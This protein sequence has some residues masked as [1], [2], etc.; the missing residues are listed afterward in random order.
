LAAI[1]NFLEE[2]FA[3]S[4]T[5]KVNLLKKDNGQFIGVIMQENGF[6]V[7]AACGELK[8]RSAIGKMLRMAQV[9]PFLF[10]IIVEPEI[11]SAGDSVF[12]MSLE[13]L[14]AFIKDYNSQQDE[15]SKLKPPP[16]MKILI[17]GEFIVEGAQ[18]TADEF[19]T[20]LVAVDYAKVAEIY[21]NCPLPEPYITKALI[22][23]RKKGAIKVIS[24]D[25]LGG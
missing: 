20:M 24:V 22:D 1:L 14:Y 9:Q 4:F 10:K 11:I 17:R 2:N 8:G 6:I 23:L 13:D 7:N 5:G 21:N 3:F 15:M 25:N 16:N 12:K 19:E 18:I